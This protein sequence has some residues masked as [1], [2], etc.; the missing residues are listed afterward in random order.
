MKTSNKLLQVSL[1]VAMLVNTD[2]EE[3]FLVVQSLPVKDFIC[4]KLSFN[5]E[6]SLQSI[7][8]KT[9]SLWTSQYI[10]HWLQFLPKAQRIISRTKTPLPPLNTETAKRMKL[11]HW[12]SSILA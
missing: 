5:P 9:A 12:T 6:H 4:Q 7:K 10:Q 11:L 3:R 1:F 8:T 2:Q